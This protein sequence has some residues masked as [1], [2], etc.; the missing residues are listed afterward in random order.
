MNLRIGLSL[1][2]LSLLSQTVN[3]ACSRVTSSATLSQ[4]AIDA[5]YTAASWTGAC[6]TCNAKNIGIPGV[7]SLSNGTFQ[8]SGTLLASS[9]MSF[10][11]QGAATAY[12]ANQIL[13]RCAVADADSLYEMYATNGD[14]T[15]TGMYAAS[16][17]D[18]AY[19]SYMRNVAVRLTNL[20]TG[21]Y[22][23]RYWQGR[24]LTEDDWFS[25]GTWIYVP[26]SAFSDV[27]MEIFRIDSTTWFANA[28][29]RYT[30][31]YSQPHGYSI[32]K[33]PGLSTN[34][35]EGADSASY[36]DGFYSAWPGSWSLY[37]AGVTFVRGATCRVNDFPNTVILPTITATE[38]SQGGASQ[39]GF[40]VTIECETGAVSSTSVSTTS[41]A[42]VSMGFLVNQPK[43]VAAAT[44]LGLVTSGGGL[45]WLLDNN[46]GAGAGEASGVGIRIYKS[47]G[48]ALNLLPNL[49]ASSYGQ[50]NPRGWYAFRDLTTLVSSGS[51]EIYAGD[52][53]ASLEAINQQPITAGT[54]NA[55][56]Q[57]MVSFQ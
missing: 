8:S 19:Y 13:F 2:A 27:L 32:F 36:W 6:D 46:Y 51:T 18:G 38:L 21:A 41:S 34:V 14:N 24:K 25:D 23:S 17:I 30:Y 47:D 52:F 3:A 28:A 40:N 10:L 56:L 22:F 9:S 50:G 53:T 26:A 20:R 45:T 55:Q 5:G 7:I 39:T 11:S 35:T 12:S 49:T 31:T 57:I 44:S 1:L 43:A 4:A 42:N 37:A 54:V 15:Y 33:G 48:S 29:N 16:E